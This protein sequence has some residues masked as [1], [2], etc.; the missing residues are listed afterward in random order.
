MATPLRSTCPHCGSTDL[1]HEQR[2]A[3]PTGGTIPPPQAYGHWI[4]CQACG[5]EWPGDGRVEEAGDD[6]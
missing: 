6:A 2:D 3:W 4:V 5:R 1:V